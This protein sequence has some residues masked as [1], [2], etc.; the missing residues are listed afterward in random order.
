MTVSLGVPTEAKVLIRL[1]TLVPDGSSWHRT[2]RRMGV[3]WRKSTGGQVNLRI[4]PGGVV[5]EEG[6]MIRKMRIG[7]LQ[8]AAI[9]NAGLAEI[10]PSAY[11]LMLPMMFD[12]YQE[13]DY[14]RQ[15]VNPI[16]ERNL[17]EK[18]FVVLAWSDVGWVYFFTRKPMQRPDELKQMK[19]AG[20]ASESTSVDIFKWA[21]F[22]PVPITIV[23]MVTGLQTG[24]IDALYS[25]IIM[26]EGSQF[27]RQAKNMTDMK[28]APL[29]GAVVMH[30]KGWNRLSPEQQDTI[31]KI[32]REVGEKL[33]RDNRQLEER[34]NQAA[35]L[36]RGLG[37]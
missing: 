25:P 18:G 36:F 33:R 37:L 21:G 29:Q 24:L 32:T 13:W 8:A 16:L 2:L 1:G 7:Q 34:S 17:R 9:S 11:A 20:S 19:L 14:V 35:Q 28:W 5:G 26:A 4:F 22:N 3:E 27:Y 23:D 12:S 15:K 6:D 31:V 10:D 30:E